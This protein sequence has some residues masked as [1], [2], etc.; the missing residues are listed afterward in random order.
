M[1]VCNVCGKDLS[2]TDIF[3]YM[4]KSYCSD[5]CTNSFISTTCTETVQ[6]NLIEY[7]AN[8]LSCFGINL[9]EKKKL[10]NV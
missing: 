10:K 3:R 2:R 1:F 5:L 8:V 4:D 9:S 6:S 7:F